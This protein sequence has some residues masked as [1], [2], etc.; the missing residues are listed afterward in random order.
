ME[1]FKKG[2]QK[3]IKTN[4]EPN[5]SPRN[6]KRKKSPNFLN[7]K[8]ILQTTFERKQPCDSK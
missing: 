3:I 1:V 7:F 6:K 5:I 8:N 2:K 4:E